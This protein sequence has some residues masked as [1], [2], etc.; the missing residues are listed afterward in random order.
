MQ[1]NQLTPGAREIRLLVDRL[2]QD[3]LIY[4]SIF[5]VSA[6]LKRSITLSAKI[7]SL[8]DGSA[9]PVQGR[10]VWEP[11][12]WSNLAIGYRKQPLEPDS[13]SGTPDSLPQ[14][15]VE[16][17][18][19]QTLAQP[20]RIKRDQKPSESSLFTTDEDGTKPIERTSSIPI[21]RNKPGGAFSLPN[22]DMTKSEVE[23]QPDKPLVSQIFIEEDPGEQTQEASDFSGTV[24]PIAPSVRELSRRGGSQPLSPIFK[25]TPAPSQPTEASDRGSQQESFPNR[26]SPDKSKFTKRKIVSSNNIPPIFGDSS[27]KE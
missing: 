13:L 23:A 6:S 12:N 17:P 10:I 16:L 18:H 2:P 3:T 27:K 25:E 19:S 22:P 4:G 21:L 26:R 8:P 9:G 1:P 7:Q 20:P 11:D 24:D 15:E 5:L 14:Q